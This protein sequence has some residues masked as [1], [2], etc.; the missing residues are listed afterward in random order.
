VNGV[1]L[2]SWAFDVQIADEKEKIDVS[3]FN[4]TNSREYVPGSR[5]QAVTVQFVN[6]RASGGPHATIEPLYT[7]GSVF[8]FFVQADSDA[9]TSATNPIYGGSASCYSFPTGATLNEREEMAIEFAPAPNSVFAW[10]TV[11][12]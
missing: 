11:A 5:D 7:G 1:V 9:G 12:P 4:P 6:D 8:A 3:G 10:G 2:S